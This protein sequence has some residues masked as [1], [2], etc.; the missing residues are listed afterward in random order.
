MR[1]RDELK[2]WLGIAV[3]EKEEADK[4]RNDLIH[5]VETLNANI[6]TLT[7][8]K[9]KLAGSCKTY[10]D[11]EKANLNYTHYLEFQLHETK[12]LHDEVVMRKWEG[13]DRSGLSCMYPFNQID[14]N[15]GGWVYV[16]CSGQL[17]NGSY[18][19]NIF[20]QEWDEIWNSEMARKLRYSV[21]CGDF[22]YCNNKCYELRREPGIQNGIEYNPIIPREST[23][24]K[25]SSWEECIQSEAPEYIAITCD[26]SCNLICPSCR[27]KIKIISED[28]SDMI[29]QMLVEKIEPVLGGCKRLL[30]IG[31]GE[32]FASAAGQRFLKRLDRK[33]QPE[34]SLIL[35]SNGQ[36][37]TEKKWSEFQ[38]LSE[39]PVEFCI[40][41]DGACRETYEILR[42]G[43]K[44]DRLQENLGFISGLVQK[45]QVRLCLNFVIQLQNYE[46]LPGL[47]EM[48]KRYHAETIRIIRLQ[49]WGT[50]AEEEYRNLDV[51]NP[52]HP[53]YEEVMVCIRKVTCEE[54]ITVIQ[55]II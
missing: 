40:S 45:S 27:D 6:D 9:E 44:W 22:E 1:E 33:K 46:E 52:D 20:E 53:R 18:I 15:I 30:M 54:G 10:E 7:R 51:C 26:E 4:S 37:L 36:L 16:C 3:R 28:E 31:S 5:E 42:R 47:V 48:A 50:Y 55:N 43:G 35:Y 39:F 29:Y 19:G 34:M 32:I 11:K 14:I 24:V 2:A 21:T 23:G 49:N 17:K 25:Y 38:N 12:I 41:V 13:S 8:E